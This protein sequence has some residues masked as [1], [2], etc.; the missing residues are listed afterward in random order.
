MVPF[1]VPFKA[2]RAVPFAVPL[3]AARAV[4]FNAALAVP[5]NAALA[6][7]F[8][9]ARVVPLVEAAF[10][11]ELT[12]PLGVL[13]MMAFVTAV[14]FAIKDFFSTVLPPQFFLNPTI[15]PS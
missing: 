9:I 1:A 8:A 2:A 4:P 14:R 10:G 7:P 13:A 15:C 6:V 11:A 5:F 3:S 12:S